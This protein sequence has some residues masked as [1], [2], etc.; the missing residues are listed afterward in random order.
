MKKS[1]WTI[2]PALPSSGSAPPL[3]PSQSIH[4][5]SLS[6]LLCR[7]SVQYTLGCSAD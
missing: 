3:L 4:Y 7:L 6:P 1:N 2:I 5:L